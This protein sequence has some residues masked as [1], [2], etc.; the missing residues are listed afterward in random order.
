MS[1]SFIPDKDLA[2][3]TYE[4]KES[5]KEFDEWAEKAPPKKSNRKAIMARL[6]KKARD[7][8]KI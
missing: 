4:A 2:F 3:H 8:A 7:K 6:E 1:G 5:L